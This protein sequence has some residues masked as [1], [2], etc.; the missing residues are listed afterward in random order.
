MFKTCIY[1]NFLIAVANN[2]DFVSSRLYGATDIRIHSLS[3]MICDRAEAFEL[4]LS[5]NSWS[6]MLFMMLMDK[7]SSVSTDT[8]L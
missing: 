7:Y 5:T 8:F 2:N 3:L 6:S 1:E 4:T